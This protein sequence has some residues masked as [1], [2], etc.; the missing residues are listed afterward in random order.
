MVGA[1]GAG[2]GKVGVQD[3][4]AAAS[5]AAAVK[6]GKTGNSTAAAALHQH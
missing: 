2:F 1:S 4:K 3:A 6:K 5:K